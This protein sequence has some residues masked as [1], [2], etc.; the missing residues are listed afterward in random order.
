MEEK[1]NS[2]IGLKILGFILLC[3]AV[4][5][6]VM[7]LLGA[8]KK[9]EKNN[10][11][12]NN[13]PSEYQ[14]IDDNSDNKLDN[15]ENKKLVEEM[16]TYA[17]DI[18]YSY[19]DGVSKVKLDS[20]GYISSKELEKCLPGIGCQKISNWEDV[21]SKFTNNFIGTLESPADGCMV[22]IIDNVAYLKDGLNGYAL[23]S[24]D[25]VD[26][27]NVEDNIISAHVSASLIG[28]NGIITD[29]NGNT[30]YSKE[31]KFIDI[32]IIKENDTW[33]VDSFKVN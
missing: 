3:V 23:K 30:K 7:S 26:V 15:D 24:I 12:S 27:F 6:I 10:P 18:L 25:D 19:R 28:L 33:K 5:A 4:V 2:K 20:E 29:E 13:N 32:S 21:S 8:F 31:V 22:I 14:T 9:K 11:N 16:T 17:I 1:K